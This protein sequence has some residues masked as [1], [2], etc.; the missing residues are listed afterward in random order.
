MA[1]DPDPQ[2]ARHK[3]PGRRHRR[4]DPTR[5]FCCR[6]PAYAGEGGPPTL[7]PM[8]LGHLGGGPKQ[9]SCIPTLTTRCP[10]TTVP[11]NHLASPTQPALG[12]DA[13]H[14]GV[15]APAWPP[16]PAGLGPGPGRAS[17]CR[18]ARYAGCSA[19]SRGGL[20][21]EPD[22]PLDVNTAFPKRPVAGLEAIELVAPSWAG[23]WADHPRGTAR[24]LGTA[25][26]A[27]LQGSVLMCPA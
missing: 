20:V 1:V 26:E 3:S 23:D 13:A 6:S 16:E 21:A 2:V 14:S 27:V 22:G 8:P 15:E 11:S 10:S 25:A 17:R 4:G 5:P 24:G 12:H 7:H 9:V 19:S 18:P